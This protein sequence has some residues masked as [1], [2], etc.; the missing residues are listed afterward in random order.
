MSMGLQPKRDRQPTLQSDLSSI[1]S[2]ID[3]DLGHELRT[4][5]TAIR[6]ALGLLGTGLLG[7]LSD[8]GQRMVSIAEHNVER[9]LKLTALIENEWSDRSINPCVIDR[10]NEL[11]VENDLRSAVARQE[12]QLSYQPIVSLNNQEIHGFEAL[13]R[14]YHPSLGVIPPSQFIP[15]AEASDLIFDLGQWVLESA[16]SQ[17]SEWQKNLPILEKQ[18]LFMSV[19]LSSRQLTSDSLVEQVQSTLKRTGIP[20]NCLKLEITESAVI[21][22]IDLA[23]YT[24]RCLREMGVRVCIDDFGTGF[25]SLSRL[26]E[27]PLDVLKIDR[28]FVQHLDSDKGE[29]LITII[30]ALAKDLKIDLIAEG[31]ELEEQV[32][33]LQSLGCYWGQGFLFSRALTAPQI[34]TLVKQSTL[35]ESLLEK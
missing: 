9:L 14:W 22:N 27:L 5:L 24:L 3:I 25:S 2:E 4:P 17:L 11:R 32:E 28:S 33:K 19:N 35:V 10:L 6:G 16:C 18:K 12:L 34:E 15:L 31:V 23:E 30:A 26:F 8:Q 1:V 29:I 7:S 21:D 13:V 20:A